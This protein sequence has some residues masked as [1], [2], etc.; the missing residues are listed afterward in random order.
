[1]KSKNL[2][3]IDPLK[4]FTELPV[5][6]IIIISSLLL[7]LVS[8][9]LIISNSNL[10][11]NLDYIGFNSFVE[12]FKV[13][14]SILAL[15]ITSI[16]IIATI[17]RSSQIKEQILSANKQNTFS[18]YFKHIEEF[19]KYMKVVI[20]TKN[21]NLEN[22]RFTHKYL[23]PYA[24]DGNYSINQEFLS[25]INNRFSKIKDLLNK[26]NL[27]R[28]E[29]VSDLLFEIYSE[30]DYNFSVL[31]IK[32]LRSGTQ[33]VQ[34]SKRIVVPSKNIFAIMNDIKST[35]LIIIH[36]IA[37]D[38]QVEIPS[39]LYQVA[40]LIISKEVPNWNFQSTNKFENFVH[41][42]IVTHKKDFVK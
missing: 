35:S 41:F 36:I 6:R 29:T 5:F 11:W 10:I 39:P 19:E 31:H 8:T 32:C 21:Y 27:E 26:F 15:A 28:T 16:A 20:P 18:N 38:P 37:F 23:F 40:N 2:F 14:L 22:L 24:F 3:K 25:I 12:I 1:V 33:I 9:L 7:S 30:I 13:P 42:D 34:D 17:H 4:S